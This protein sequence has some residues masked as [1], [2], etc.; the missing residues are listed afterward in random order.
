MPGAIVTRQDP[1]GRI[2]LECAS[3]LALRKLVQ[4]DVVVELGELMLAK[5][6]IELLRR[7]RF[8][9]RGSS[10][11][12]LRIAVQHGRARQMGFRELRV[13]GVGALDLIVGKSEPFFLFVWKLNAP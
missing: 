10:L 1:A 4:P 8:S 9:Y 13:D 7:A 11:I 5:V 6:R 2:D 12:T 3:I